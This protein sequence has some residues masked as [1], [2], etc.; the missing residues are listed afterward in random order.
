MEENGEGGARGE[1]AMEAGEGVSER[2]W[3]G[4]EK[5]EAGTPPPLKRSRQKTG[6]GAR[7]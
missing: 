7:R 6:A 5:T 3:R 1:K 2:W 4:G